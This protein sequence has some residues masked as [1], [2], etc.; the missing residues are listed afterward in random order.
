MPIKA[1]PW[2]Y[3]LHVRDAGN[4][5]NVDEEFSDAMGCV[6]RPDQAQ[7]FEWADY[8]CDALE[9]GWQLNGGFS[10][11]RSVYVMWPQTPNI[12]VSYNADS[13][14]QNFDLNMDMQKE[15]YDLD[16]EDCL[17]LRQSCMTKWSEDHGHYIAMCWQRC[18]LMITPR[19]DDPDSQDALHRATF[20][21]F[22]C[23]ELRAYAD[24]CDR[25][26]QW[27][28]AFENQLSLRVRYGGN[29][30]PRELTD[31]NQPARR[32]RRRMDCIVEL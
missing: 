11:A 21:E 8:I 6:M 2:C 24:A 16:P 1:M 14:E 15:R 12:F 7:L 29:T 28:K 18:S 5:G 19:P 9:E 23:S 25:A 3:W 26:G 10:P 22:M 30:M 32:T 31:N 20:L 13:G 4:E 17:P 27:W